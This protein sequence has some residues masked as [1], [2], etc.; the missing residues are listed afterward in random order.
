LGHPQRDKAWWR[1]VW[2][3]DKLRVTG[4]GKCKKEVPE[5]GSL[6]QLLN[7]AQSNA[8]PIY[9]V[10]SYN[11]LDAAK[12]IEKRCEMHNIQEWYPTEADF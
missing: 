10:P 12:F 1:K 5:I 6:T 2:G 3:V 8:S 9:K 11:A 7:S 4:N